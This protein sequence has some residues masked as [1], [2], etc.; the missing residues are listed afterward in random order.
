[1]G[2][3]NGCPIGRLEDFSSVECVSLA[4]ALVLPGVCCAVLWFC[5]VFV[6]GAACRTVSMSSAA[7]CCGILCVCQDV[8]L[9]TC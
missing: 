3:A 7:S 5:D 9:K 6:P 4:V 1:M 8:F 2:A